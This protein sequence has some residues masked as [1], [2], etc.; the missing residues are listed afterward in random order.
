MS[1]AIPPRLDTPLWRDA[2]LKYKD[3]FT[4]TFSYTRNVYKILVGVDGG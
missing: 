4:F 1:E 2:Q 3:N